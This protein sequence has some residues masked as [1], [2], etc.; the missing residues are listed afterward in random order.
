[1]TDYRAL[2]AELAV[3]RLPGSTNNA[4]VRAALKRELGARGFVVTEQPFAASTRQL[5]RVALGGGVVGSG[6]LA[7]L[8]VVVSSYRS[9]PIVLWA[10]IGSAIV[11]AVGLLL[12][13]ASFFPTRWIPARTATGV[14]LIGVRPGPP[15]ACWLAAHYDS[16]GQPISMATRLIAGALVGLEVPCLLGL[17]LWLRTAGPGP[18]ASVL[19]LPGIV[20][21]LVLSCNR[22]TDASPGAL[23]NVSGLVA[24]LAAVDALPADAPVGVLFP[25]AEEFGLQGARALVRQ[26]AGLFAGTTVVNLDG[27]DDRGGPIAF[28]HRRGPTVDAVVERLGAHRARLLPVLVDGIEFARAAPECLSILRGDWGTA[29]IVHTPRDTVD[30]LTLTGAKEVAAAVAAVLSDRGGGRAR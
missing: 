6:L 24:V 8:L 13:L 23:D 18:A 15:V 14:N 26:R 27:L 2:L 19:L 25:D 4:R 21:G 3:P 10:A 28:V 20:G 9:P 1:M 22:A 30:R 29:R 16:K 17:F 5:R 12:F 7:F 11:F